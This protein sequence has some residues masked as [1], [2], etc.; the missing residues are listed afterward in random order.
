MPHFVDSKINE[1]LEVATEYFKALVASNQIDAEKRQKQSAGSIGFIPYNVSFTMDGISGI[2][3]YNELSLDTNFLP[4]G[5]TKT[6]D[7]I[8]TGVSHTLKGNDWET[9]IETT[10]IGKT[11]NVVTPTRAGNEVANTAIQEPF[12]PALGAP[13]TPPSTPPD[14]NATGGWKVTNAGGSKTTAFD[15]ARHHSYDKWEADP[16]N[17][18]SGGWSQDSSGR[19]MYDLVLFRE[20][21]GVLTKRCYIPS[22]VNGTVTGVGLFT[23]GSASYIYIKDSSGAQYVLL[24]CDNELVRVGDT[25]VKG[26]LIARQSDIMNNAHIP[27]NVHLHIQFPSK[28]VLVE[29]I[30]KLW[31]NGPW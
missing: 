30:S 26:Q 4:A 12:Q 9:E 29:Y 6:T 21:N 25:V 20:E 16:S 7:F 3:I 27:P 15:L 5:Y 1:N 10:V 22:P 13:S 28:Q 2:K 11:G 18:A 17:R 23:N 14:I 31:T 24:H 19:Y 8:V